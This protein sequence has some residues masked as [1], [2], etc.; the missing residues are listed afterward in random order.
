MAPTRHTLGYGLAAAMA[1]GC[2]GSTAL[3]SDAGTDV[4]AADVV[5]PVDAVAPRDVTVDAGPLNACVTAADCA[6]SEIRAEIN[7]PADC[8]CLLG[9]PNTVL[10][11]DVAARRQRQYQALCTPGRSGNGQPC[12]IDDC[13]MPPALLCRNGL[14]V[15]PGG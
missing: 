13:A 7:A 10:N 4:V 15:A 6:W 2:G 8:P 1:L 12:P 11:R 5:A 9:C 3:R 14:C